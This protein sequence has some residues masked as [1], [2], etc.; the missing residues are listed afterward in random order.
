M[1]YLNEETNDVSAEERD[2]DSRADMWC[3]TLGP[4]TQSRSLVHSQ[5]LN[6]TALSPSR[7][8]PGWFDQIW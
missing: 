5:L 2:G 8:L 4:L 6:Y 7:K 1:T 3:A